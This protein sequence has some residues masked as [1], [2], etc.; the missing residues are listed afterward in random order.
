MGVSEIAW[1][2]NFPPLNLYNHPSYQVL[3]VWAQAAKL[4]TVPVPEHIR[5]TIL[6][7]ENKG[8]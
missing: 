5:Q 2:D 4:E 8:E 1:N 7:G 6:Y 3:D